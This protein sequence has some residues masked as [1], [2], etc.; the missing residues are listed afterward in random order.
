M[1]ATT[2]PPVLAQCS[3]GALWV[4]EHL[5]RLLRRHHHPPALAGN[6]RVEAAT[7]FEQGLLEHDRLA[8]MA[9]MLRCAG[10]LDLPVLEDA[11][12]LWQRGHPPTAEEKIPVSRVLGTA[13]GGSVAFDRDFRPTAA[14]ARGRFVNAFVAMYEGGALSPIDVVAWQG[15][16]YVI[17]GHHRVAAARALGQEF[18]DARVTSV[19][20]AG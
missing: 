13:G 17:D 8:R 20:G 7:A 2:Q 14:S 15:A 6:P 16:Y 4:V 11:A 9:A 5:M 12:P 3:A 10:Q 1:V 18:L 19:S